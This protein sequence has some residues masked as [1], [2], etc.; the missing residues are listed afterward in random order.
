M[1][2]NYTN[3]F[4]KVY[5][6]SIT[7]DINQD[8][9]EILSEVGIGIRMKTH[10]IQALAQRT[11]NKQVN[12][13]MRDV[14]STDDD[15]F[16][17]E[18]SKKKS[19]RRPKTNILFTPPTHVTLSNRFGPLLG[20]DEINQDSETQNNQYQEKQQEQEKQSKKQ[21]AP[22]LNNR[23]TPQS[24]T[25]VS[26]RK[27]P[28]V[29]IKQVPNHLSFIK[30]C[31]KITDDPNLICS[32]TVEG[33]KIQPKS[34]ESHNK[35]TKHLMTEKIEYH[36]FV[37]STERPLK[38]V[39]KQLPPT[40]TE[41]ELYR[42]L[43]RLN[44]PVKAVRQFTTK[45]N[46]SQEARKLP[47]WIVTLENSPEGAALQQCTGLFNIKMIIESYRPKPTSHYVAKELPHYYAKN[48]FCCIS[49]SSQCNAKKHTAFNGFQSTLTVSG[50]EG[51]NEEL[52][53][54]TIRN[55]S[56]MFRDIN[57]NFPETAFNRKLKETEYQNEWWNII[58]E[59]H[60]SGKPLRR[61][62]DGTKTINSDQEN[63]QQ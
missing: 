32:Y 40:I 28:P 36:T 5:S 35:L 60:R 9:E 17:I 58:P 44:Y 31:V 27:P 4:L 43:L 24:S 19:T 53:A 48:K 30:D 41:D 13:R 42:E 56:P 21:Q 29:I 3:L 2:N 55:R 62:L 18:K 46:D 23:Q 26:S 12:K 59:D 57:R 25:S 8:L 16:Q 22:P 1:K 52:L 50:N 14:S 11:K 7:Y 63:L 61:L 45:A 47:I 10:I 37:A 38:L 39:I 20:E 49:I 54:I 15:D 51:F 34:S 6:P 33:L